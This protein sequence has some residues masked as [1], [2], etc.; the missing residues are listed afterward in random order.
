MLS[1]I[2]KLAEMDYSYSY[3]SGSQLS[4]G[5]IAVMAAFFSTFFLLWLAVGLAILIGSWRIFQK[6]GKP[7]WAVLVPFY[8]I[9]VLLDIVGRPGWWLLLFFVP[10]VNMVISLILAFDTARA[11]GKS[12]LFAVLGLFFF[13]PIGVLMLGF[14][15]AKYLGRKPVSLGIDPS[16]TEAEVVEKSTGNHTSP[17]RPTKKS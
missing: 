16:L 12:E 5:A 11:F 1:I 9:W 6:A 2:S 10:I 14:G 15:D 13:N 4:G 3:N 7:G 17:K 8:N